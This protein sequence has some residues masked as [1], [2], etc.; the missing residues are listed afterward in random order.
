MKRFII[1]GFLFLFFISFANAALGLSPAKVEV[2]FKPNLVQEFKFKVTSDNPEKVIKMY[3][4]GDLK[5]YVSFDKENLVGGGSFTASL[6]LPEKIENPGRNTIIIGVEEEVDPEVVGIGTRIRIQAPIHIDVPYPG[7]YVEVYLTGENANAG[8]DIEFILDISNKGKEDV[9]ISPAIDI[10]KDEDFIQR[11][12][13]SLRILKSQEEIKLKKT[14]QTNNYLPG[15]YSAKAMV[16]YTTK[17]S[18]ADFRIG[19]LFVDIYNYTSKIELS[20]GVTKF[21][22]DIENRWNNNIDSVYGQ[23]SFSKNE[24]EL[25]SFKTSPTNLLPWQ[26]SSVEGFF[27]MSNFSEG[28]YPT[29][30]TLYYNGEKTSRLVNVNFYRDKVDFMFYLAILSSIVA[31]T[32]VLYFVYNIFKGRKRKNGKNARKR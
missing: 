5:D 6:K 16:D 8:E 30:I 3:A 10:Y 23:V 22:I 21:V 26:K 32:L 2:D 18:N 28:D 7:K 19:S 13:L 9:T 1:L 15:D 27:D 14:L 31:L 20:K 29:N 4:S 17:E 12:E 24:A 11:L 25:I